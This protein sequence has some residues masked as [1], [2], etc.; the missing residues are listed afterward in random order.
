MPTYEYLCEKCGNFDFVQKITEDALKTCP[1]CGGSVKRLI[2]A[3][4]FH[5]KGS[6]WYKTDYGSS[7][8]RGGSPAGESSNA[9]PD[10]STGS[11]DSSPKA[12]SSGG[13][14]AAS[15]ATESVKPAASSPNPSKGADEK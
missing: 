2:S 15:S 7:G 10:K 4:A 13:G 9:S 6:G 3:T 1:T 5:L 14:A 8:S 12:D 11:A